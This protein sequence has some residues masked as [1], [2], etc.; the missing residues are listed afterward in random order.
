MM[1][2]CK[3]NKI[4]FKFEAVLPSMRRGGTW[5]R[6]LKIL[7]ASVLK[8]VRGVEHL[9]QKSLPNGDKKI[10]WIFLI[11]LQRLS[12]ECPNGAATLR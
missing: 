4:P 8:R 1:K 10:W 5:Q 3:K 9:Y 6:L 11:V 12:G 7:K 2:I